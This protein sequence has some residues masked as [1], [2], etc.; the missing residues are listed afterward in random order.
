MGAMSAD[1]ECPEHVWRAR[2][3]TL[4]DGGSSLVDYVCER[5]GSVAVAGA[6]DMRGLGGGPGGDAPQ[7]RE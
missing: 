1:D 3:A 5:C 7:V 2:G 4:G 6:G